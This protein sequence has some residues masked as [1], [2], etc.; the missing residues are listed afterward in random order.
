MDDDGVEYE[1]DRWYTWTEKPR[2]GRRALSP[3]HTPRE[4]R[5][6]PPHGLEFQ[7]HML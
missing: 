4:I 1:W 2:R 5:I 6:A 7:Y 3:S